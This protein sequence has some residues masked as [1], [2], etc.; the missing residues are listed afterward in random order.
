M[1]IIVAVLAT[2]G[3]RAVIRMKKT[4]MK[5]MMNMMRMIMT[6]KMT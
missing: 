6:M 4:M 3:N 2:A 1:V 5:I